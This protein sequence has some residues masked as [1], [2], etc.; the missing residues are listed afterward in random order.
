[1]I[2]DAFTTP[3]LRLD[4]R[5][6]NLEMLDAFPPIDYAVHFHPLDMA[7]EIRPL[8]FDDDTHE[9]SS[10]DETLSV[11]SS[12]SEDFIAASYEQSGTLQE[13]AHE[14]DDD[15]STFYSAE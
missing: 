11:S 13:Y 1:M 10:T 6:E 9:V 2:D 8:N 15:M 3:P 12:T 14:Q 7:S 5:R 4:L